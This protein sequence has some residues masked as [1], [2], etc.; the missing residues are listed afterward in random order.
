MQNE[1]L[2]TLAL[3]EH[4]FSAISTNSSPDVLVVG[5]VVWKH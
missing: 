3:F 1:K 4:F 2:Q 5:L